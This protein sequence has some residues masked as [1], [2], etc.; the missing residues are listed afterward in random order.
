MSARTRKLDLRT[1]TSTSYLRGLAAAQRTLQSRIE[2]AV[3]SASVRWRYSIVL[4]ALAVDLPTAELGRLARLPGVARVWPS[5]R[6]HALGQ[7]S[8]TLNQTPR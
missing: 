1:P 4:D 7:S 5:V 6:Y 2:S 3:P 8:A